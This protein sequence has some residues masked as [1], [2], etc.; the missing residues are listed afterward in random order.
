[1]KKRIASCLP[2]SRGSTKDTDSNLRNQC[3]LL[4]CRTARSYSRSSAM[5]LIIGKEFQEHVKDQI[6][7]LW[8]KAK[9]TS[10]HLKWS[11][12][13]AQRR[14][15]QYRKGRIEKQNE[16]RALTAQLLSRN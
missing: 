3:D 7:K 1:M 2:G 14:S 12:T 10:P 6:P 5:H 8:L 11:S 9:F 16:C 15:M 4:E 13:L